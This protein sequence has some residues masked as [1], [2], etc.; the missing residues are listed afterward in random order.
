MTFDRWTCEY[1]ECELHGSMAEEPASYDNVVEV[2]G[3]VDGQWYTDL[4]IMCIC[5]YIGVKFWREWKPSNKPENSLNWA[6]KSLF[7]NY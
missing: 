4:K 3:N 7:K 5:T 2:D 6:R 1:D